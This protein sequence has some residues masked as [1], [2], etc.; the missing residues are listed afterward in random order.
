[1]N[2]LAGF[3]ALAIVVIVTPGPDT[4]LTIRNTL[5]GGRPA[6]VAT[7][8]GVALSQATWSVATSIGVAALLVAAEPA[9]A[10][11]KVAGA[12]Y[13]IYLGVQSL[14]SAL[15]GRPARPTLDRSVAR[16]RTGT[17]LRQGILSNLTNPKMAVFFPSLLPQFVAVDARPFVP[18]LAMGILFCVMT[19]AWL[20]G[21]AFAV[22]RAGDVLRRS[23][24]RRTVEAV[25]GVVLVAF[26]VRV[27][28]GSR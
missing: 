1:V 15:R 9:F 25:T 16:V 17:A 19:L 27:A 24:V 5:V 3:V 22:A 13:L 14:W 20:T 18:L 8:V 12:A 28:V 4:A 23:A 11:L 10:A 26:G 21:Y 7:A 2:D 6:G